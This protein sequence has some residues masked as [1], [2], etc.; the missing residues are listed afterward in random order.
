MARLRGRN[1]VK[2]PKN[3]ANRREEVKVERRSSRPINIDDFFFFSENVSTSMFHQSQVTMKPSG[4]T[5][6]VMRRPP[7]PFCKNGDAPQNQTQ[8]RPQLVIP[9]VIPNSSQPLK[10]KESGNKFSGGSGSVTT[11]SIPTH[12][13]SVSKFKGEKARKISSEEEARESQ[14][15]EI[16]VKPGSTSLPVL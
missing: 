10:T 9:A 5:P 3:L 8:S 13:S 4:D 6:S 2:T 7:S 14:P 1:A 16:T 11:S 12:P 15:R